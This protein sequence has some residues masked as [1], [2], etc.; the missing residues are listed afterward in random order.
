MCKISC[1][2]LMKAMTSSMGNKNYTDVTVSALYLIYD[3]F[4]KI[5]FQMKFQHFS[6]LR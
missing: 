4:Y 5:P 3:L 1:E 2:A 6:I